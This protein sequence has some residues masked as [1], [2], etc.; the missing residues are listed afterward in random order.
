MDSKKLLAEVIKDL[1]AAAE[2]EYKKG[3]ERYFK[4]SISI[5]GV[6]LAK[7]RK[8]SRK[9]FP[10]VK[11]LPLPDIFDVCEKFLDNGRS[12]TTFVAFQWAYNRRK[13]W[14]VKD[15]ARIERWLKKYVSNWAS[16]DHLSTHIFGHFITTFPKT[17]PQ[18]KSWSSS[19]NRWLRRASAVSFVIP[20]RKGRNHKDVFEVA[21]KLLLDKDDL[22]Q[23][24]YGWML[25]EASNADQKA[26]FDFVMKHKSKMPRTALRYAIEKMPSKLKKQAM[27]K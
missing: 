27:K 19:R 8:F 4:E 12:E 26:V 5:Y 13:D 6:R 23:K 21:K 25:K 18:I 14:T 20:A 2:P 1:K 22:V 17:I 7:V 11:S 3:A 16:C 15:F 24:G 10:K 9:H